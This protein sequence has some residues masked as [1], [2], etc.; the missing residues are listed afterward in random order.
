MT[1]NL[2]DSKKQLWP[3]FPLH[4]DTYSLHDFRHSE[5]EAD[6]TKDLSLA[7]I[8]KRQYDPNKASSNFTTEMKV[9]KFLHEEDEFDDLF[10]L[11]ELFS[12][13]SHLEILK[14]S[15]EK[16]CKFIEY[17]THR[18]QT[19][20][21]DL[22]SITP[23]IQQEE[24]NEEQVIERFFEEVETSDKSSE[25][26]NT[27]VHI[28]PILI[29]EREQFDQHIKSLNAPRNIITSVPPETQ[30]TII[31]NIVSERTPSKET[32][33]RGIEIISEN[34]LG[35]LTLNIEEIPPL[36]VFYSPKHTVVVKRQRKKRKIDQTSSTT[37]QSKLMNVIWKDLEV[38]PSKDLIKL[39]QFVGTYTTARN[40]KATRVNQLIKEKDQKINHLEEQLAAEQQK[41]NWLE[42][43]LTVEK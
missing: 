27:D 7:I 19:V 43:H 4:C 31:P 15:A 25:Q 30:R 14:L 37:P 12:I 2:K 42:E 16:M 8:P 1:R 9:N 40:G 23:I 32:T 28:D 29:K 38:N 3:T 6:K 41:V 36:D 18:L 33:R 34:P 10:S 26:L 24:H 21:L 5:K 20:P 39:S 22:L 35:E 13:V 17:R 11:Q